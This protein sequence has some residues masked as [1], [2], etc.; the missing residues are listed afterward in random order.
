MLSSKTG[1]SHMARICD[2]LDARIR[3]ILRMRGCQEI[4]AGL[5]A[6]RRFD[7]ISS[8]PKPSVRLISRHVLIVRSL[9]LSCW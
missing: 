2:R 1:F 5:S 6:I 8:E 3:P 7:T 4:S 9:W